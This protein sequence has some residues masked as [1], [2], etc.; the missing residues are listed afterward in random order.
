[1]SGDDEQFCRCSTLQKAMKILLFFTVFELIF[2][3]AIVWPMT[4]LIFEENLVLYLGMMIP[5]ALLT[6]IRTLLMLYAMD[7]KLD[8]F[9]REKN[10][11]FYVL[12]ILLEWA[13]L[14]VWVV[15]YYKT[16]FDECTIYDPI[17]TWDVGIINFAFLCYIYAYVLIAVPSKVLFCYIQ[18]RFYMA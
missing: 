8:F 14:S 11:Y 9:A 17:C 13:L 2:H 3:L 16:K 10:Y 7:N 15:K 1:M 6:V 18:F 12:S 5:L 4:K